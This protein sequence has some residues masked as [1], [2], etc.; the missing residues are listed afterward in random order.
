MTGTAAGSGGAVPCLLH[1]QS[2]Q[3]PSTKL[4]ES[5]HVRAAEENETMGGPAG[6]RGLER[7]AL[8]GHVTQLGGAWVS[9]VQGHVRQLLL[10]IG[11]VGPI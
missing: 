2:P 7:R 9:R 5:F 11:L 10:P 6:Q 8:F 3:V 1:S 4:S